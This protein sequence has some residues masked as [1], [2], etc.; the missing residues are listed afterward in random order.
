MY[1]LHGIALNIWQATNLYNLNNDNIWLVLK[2]IMTHLSMVF[3][4]I[5][6]RSPLSS[7]LKRHDNIWLNISV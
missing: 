7:K 6:L 2:I 4:N 5:Q 3:V 1:I